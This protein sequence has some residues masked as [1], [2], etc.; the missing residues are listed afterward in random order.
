MAT[1]TLKGNDISTSGSLPVAGS[2]APAFTVVK[3]DLSEVSL[4]DY[5]GKKLVLN[6]FPSI[7]TVYPQD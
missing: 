5:A 3:T 1:I 4:A 2:A 6:I 7:D